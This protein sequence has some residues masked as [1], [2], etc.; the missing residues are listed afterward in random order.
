MK[1]FFVG[2]KMEE[3]RGRPTTARIEMNAVLINRLIEENSRLSLCRDDMQF[4]HTNQ[5][6][7][8]SLNF[9]G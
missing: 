5:Q 7:V 8:N 6:G 4:N 9:A 1:L 3:T 2:V